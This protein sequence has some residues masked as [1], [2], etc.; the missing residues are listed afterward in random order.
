MEEKSKLSKAKIQS[1]IMVDLV[2]RSPLWALLILFIYGIIMSGAI[3][4]LMYVVKPSIDAKM[5][6]KHKSAMVEFA[7][8]KRIVTRCYEYKC[9]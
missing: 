5:K 7:G 4:F 9:S 6:R 3:W 1:M 2:F 8:E